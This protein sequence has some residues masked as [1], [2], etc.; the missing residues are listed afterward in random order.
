VSGTTR[1]GASGP[2]FAGLEPEELAALVVALFHGAARARNTGH[3]AVSPKAPWQRSAGFV[4]AHSWQAT[5][6]A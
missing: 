6:T 2:R 3:A 5:G 4:V 1:R